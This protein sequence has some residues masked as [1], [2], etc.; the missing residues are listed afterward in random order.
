MEETGLDPA[1]VQVFG[2]LPDLFIPVSNYVVTPVLAWWRDPSPVAPMDAAEVAAVHAVALDDLLDPANRMQ[3]R[4]VLSG[5]VMPGFTVNGMLVWGFT[6]WV[7]DL[8]LRLAGWERPWPRELVVDL[9]QDV[10]ALA[11]STDP[12]VA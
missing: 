12:S 1:G 7:L 5:R 4:H 3:V 10:V 8:L 11:R 9:P 2:T 6:A